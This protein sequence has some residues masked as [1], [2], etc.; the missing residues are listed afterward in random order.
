V[1]VSSFKYATAG[2]RD[3]LKHLSVTVTLV[4]DLDDPVAGASVSIRLDH[5]S[6]SSWIFTGTTGPEGTVTFSLSNAP[7]GCYTTTVTGVAAGGL[8][9]DPQDPGNVSGEFCK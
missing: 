8:T 1:N 4:D 7:A 3:G 2:G 5:D 9:W 6:G